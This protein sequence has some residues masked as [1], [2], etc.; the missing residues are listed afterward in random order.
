MMAAYGTPAAL[1]LPCVTAVRNT[2]VRMPMRRAACG[3]RT[4]GGRA[5]PLTGSSL[6]GPASLA[7]SLSN[8]VALPHPATASPTRIAV[9]DVSRIVLPVGLL[10]LLRCRRAVRAVAGR[11]PA[12]LVA[13][14]PRPAQTTP[15]AG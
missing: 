13:R 6:E 15:S 7:A 3:L 12:P 5:L 8:C 1:P 4:T 14:G 11:A 2:D 10:R 9:T